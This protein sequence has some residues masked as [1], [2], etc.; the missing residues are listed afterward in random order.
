MYVDILILAHLI[1]QP[2]HGYEIK[3]RVGQTLGSGFALNNNLLYPALRRFEESGAVVREVERH[4][5]RPD[6][7]IYRITDRGEEM[8]QSLLCDF[9]PDL[10]RDESEF[11]VRVAFFDLLDPPARLEILRAREAV[12]RDHLAHLAGVLP[13]AERHAHTGGARVI[14]FITRQ[15]EQELAWIAELARET[16][17][18]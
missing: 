12:L 1:K 4:E 8:L 6:R 5:G 10:A 2:A 18:E 7:H 17:E 13:V 15:L 11:L 3:K 16:K 9:P 14:A